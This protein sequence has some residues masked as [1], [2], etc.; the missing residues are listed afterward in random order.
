MKLLAVSSDVKT[1][2]GEKL[3]ILTGILYLAPANISGYEVCPRRSEG[4]T[5]ACLY[6]A[7]MGKF[8]NVQA[9]RIKKTKMFFEN[10][11]EFL[12][13]LSDDIKSLVKKANKINMIPAVR[14]NGTSDIDWTRF[15]I[16]NQFPDVQFY[17]YTKVLNRLSKSIPNNYHLTFSKNEVN[18]EECQSALNL[19]FNVAVVFSTKKGNPLP[20]TYMGY[21]VYNGDETDVRFKDPKGVVVGLIAKGDAK[22]DK[23]GFVVNV[24]NL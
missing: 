22:K 19:G 5:E 23:T 24:N 2:K 8:N 20:E 15:D 12:K 1:T 11:D 14:L 18:D 7:G 17:D 3:G 13:I 9:A 16:M 10:R 21:P 6:T 4:C